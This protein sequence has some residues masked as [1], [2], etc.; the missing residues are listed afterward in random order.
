M[1]NEKVIALVKK[2]QQG[3]KNALNELIGEIY[4]DLYYYIFKTVKD[5]SLAADITQESCIEI[6]TTIDKLQNPEAFSLWSKRIAYH[7]CTRHFRKTKEVLVEENEDGETIF[8]QLPDEGADALPEAVAE[9]KEFRQTI[10]AMINSLSPE[11]S[12][13]LLLYY[14]EKMSVSQIAEIQGVTEGTVKS[15]L[16]YARKAI[17]GKVEEYEEKTGTR[18]HSFAL[19]PL[20]LRFVFTAE[21][22][23]IP[24]LAVPASVAT[25][26]GTATAAGAAATAGATATASAATTVATAAAAKTVGTAL[27][28]KI[29][30]GV[31]AATVAVGGTAFG[32]SKLSKKDDAKDNSVYTED[33]SNL[34]GD[35]V[36]GN[37]EDADDAFGESKPNQ[38]VDFGQLAGEWAATKD[39]LYSF[40]VNG[41]GTITID[42]KTSKLKYDGEVGV[43][44]Y[45]ADWYILETP[46][47]FMPRDDEG[48]PPNAPVTRMF[49]YGVDEGVPQIDLMNDTNKGALLPSV[50]SNFVKFFRQSDYDAVELT[51][52]NVHSYLELGEYEEYGHVMSG[53]SG[54][55]QVGSRYMAIMKNCMFYSD[56]KIYYPGNQVTK[57]VTFNT[58]TKQMTV[59]GVV[60]NK[61]I[62]LETYISANSCDSEAISLHTYMTNPKTSDENGMIDA[63]VSFVEIEKITAVEGKVYVKKGSM[64][65]T[66]P[67]IDFSDTDTAFAEI[68]RRS[69]FD[70]VTI[71]YY[72]TADVEALMTRDITLKADGAEYAVWEN[73]SVV[74]YGK[75]LPEEYDLIEYVDMLLEFAKEN[76]ESFKY[77]AAT[78]TYT[79]TE[80][81]T[82][83]WSITDKDGVVHDMLETFSEFSLEIDDMGRIY[84]VKCVS[85][86]T[87][88]ADDPDNNGFEYTGF[89]TSTTYEIDDYGTTLI[90]I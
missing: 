14:Y 15:R 84:T 49:V 46:L 42:G 73:G 63:E 29:I 60:G 80:E 3:D 70:N 37:E 75:E 16:N 22:G 38:A 68:S 90:R 21:K 19:L 10:M 83:K 71:S 41:D 81:L 66:V 57:S 89:R 35:E 53:N 1:N 18:L 44:G 87:H 78:K 72:A 76:S 12:N 25:T 34:A 39:T 13:A 69:D 62:P 88:S 5:E 31:L 9:D 36:F 4:N 11:Q 40:K 17:K 45:T 50:R 28:A 24:A 77:N 30:A 26:V 32:V 65:E 59:N 56:I 27:S 64:N 86:P 61:K 6:I 51:S 74:S 48:G 55:A 67:E 20:L 82:L 7:Q 58:E 2:S 52:D 8:D 23:S 33:G 79:N 43:S 54:V 85:I 47:T